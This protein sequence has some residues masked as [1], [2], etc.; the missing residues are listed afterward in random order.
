MAAR[1]VYLLENVAS[2]FMSTFSFAYRALD[3]SFTF[4]TGANLRF[5]HPLLSLAGHRHRFG[6]SLP[7]AYSI[8]LAC[9]RVKLTS[10]GASATSPIADF[11]MRGLI[12]RNYPDI[13]YQKVNKFLSPISMGFRT[14]STYCRSPGTGRVSVLGRGLLPAASGSLSPMRHAHRTSICLTGPAVLQYV[15]S[16]RMLQ[17]REP[18][19]MRTMDLL[20]SRPRPGLR[21]QITTTT[22]CRQTAVR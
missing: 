20:E 21:A 9:H 22:S 5:G 4:T 10:K 1:T 6:Y 19:T 15:C 17:T 7:L 11:Q 12:Q 16:T 14:G 18:R 13:R 3:F 2:F 8:T